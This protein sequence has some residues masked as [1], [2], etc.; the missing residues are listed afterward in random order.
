MKNLKFLKN[1]QKY[2]WFFFF[3]NELKNRK[4]INF[5]L[6]GSLQCRLSVVKRRRFSGHRFSNRNFS[7][8]STITLSGED[9]GCIFRNRT[10]SR[11]PPPCSVN[12]PPLRTERRVTIHAPR[13]RHRRKGVRI[14]RCGRWRRYPSICRS[15]AITVTN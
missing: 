14:I 1:K 5:Y 9:G 2:E 7:S 12:P 4:I 3:L 6:P 11:P 15:W 8:P 10:K 13:D